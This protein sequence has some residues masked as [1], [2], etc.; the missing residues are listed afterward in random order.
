MHEY[1][2]ERAKHSHQRVCPHVPHLLR[3]GCSA[4]FRGEALVPTPS[5]CTQVNL[6]YPPSDMTIRYNCGCRT[7]SRHVLIF[8]FL[9]AGACSPSTPSRAL[10]AR[11]RLNGSANSC[12]TPSSVIRCS[13]HSRN[14]GCCIRPIS[15]CRPLGLSHHSLN[16]GMNFAESK[17]CT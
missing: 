17:K 5:K 8:C 7:D 3:H 4:T 14:A 16:S 2:C 13:C 11:L 6:K 10:C 9:V 12:D 15:G 1:Q